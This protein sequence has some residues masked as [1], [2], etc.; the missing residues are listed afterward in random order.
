MVVALL[1]L[2][3][4]RRRA[5]AICCCRRIS[6]PPACGSKSFRLLPAVPPERRVVYCNGLGVGFMLSR[7]VGCIIGYYPDCVAA[8]V[9]D[10]GDAVP[11]AD[12]VP[13]LDRAQCAVAGRPLALAFGLIICPLLVYADIGLDL[14]WTGIIARDGSLWRPSSARTLARG[15]AMSGYEGLWGYFVLVL[16][17]FLPA[18]VWR[19]LGV[20]VGARARRGIRDADLGARGRDCGARR[21]SSPRS[22]SSRPDRWRPCRCRCDLRRSAAA[23]LAFLLVRR[24]VFAGRRDRRSDVTARGR[25]IPR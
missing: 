12:V 5:R 6:P 15:P 9:A 17:G 22:C 7:P 18:D 3:R 21:A 14:M 10:G 11:D 24:S 20:V 8:A 23:S 1:P 2:M 4:G 25:C 19:M 13:D 16:V